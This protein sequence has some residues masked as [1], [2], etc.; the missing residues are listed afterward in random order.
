MKDHTR[1]LPRM[2]LS[3]IIVL[4]FGYALVSHWSN[5]LEETLKNMVLIVAGFWL[6]SAQDRDKADAGATGRPG[7]PVHTTEDRDDA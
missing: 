2:A 1:D 7:D 4:Y 6:G 5:G 3:A